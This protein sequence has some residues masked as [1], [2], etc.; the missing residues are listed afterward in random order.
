MRAVIRADAAQQLGS[1]HVIRTLVLAR[2]L[3]ARGATVTYAMRE[4]DGDMREF[5]RAAGFRVDPAEPPD[6]ASAPVDLLVVDCYAL[7]ARYERS[8]RPYA[9][10]IAVIDDLADRAHDCDVLIDQNVPGSG[11]GRYAGLVPAHARCLLGPRYALLREE[12]RPY[13]PG[14][15]VRASLER[16]LVAMGGFDA[17]NQTMKV[18]RAI[19][20]LRAAPAVD[21]VLPQDAPHAAQVRALCQERRYTYRGRA[22]NIATLMESA[23]LCIGAAGMTTWERCAMGL[24]SIVIT[25]AQN[26]FAGATFARE[27]GA[28]Q[29]LGDFSVVDE[30][31]I[32]RTMTRLQG[33]AA[34]LS[35]MSSA[36]RAVVGA[37]GGE[38]T[39][40]RTLSSLLEVCNAN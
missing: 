7:G 24:P 3:A 5:V 19:G 38:F 17:Q 34:A 21:V 40:D 26:Q 35:A 32:T 33:D 8:M 16:I 39:T 30:V 27:C 36:A 11:A 2:A 10:T 4:G 29:L 31:A 37:G 22:G 14:V 25:L 1:G 20:A 13:W 6:T 12:F 23:D 9:K 18:L 15:R 28:I